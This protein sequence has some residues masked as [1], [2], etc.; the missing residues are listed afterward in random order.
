MARGRNDPVT[1]AGI[2]AWTYGL[3]IQYGV[4]RADDSALRAV[5]EAA[6]IAAGNSNDAVLI[7]TEY[8]LAVTLLNRS[9]VAGRQRGVELMTRA[10]EVWLREGILF[11]VP[12]T[13]LWVARETARR[14]DHDA[15]LPLMRNVVADMHQE[16]RLGYGVWATGVLVQTLLERGLESDLAE[17]EEV[18]DRLANLLADEL[19]DAR[20]HTASDARARGSGPRQQRRLPGFGEPLSRDGEIA[21]LRGPH[22][23]GRGD[24]VTAAASVCAGC[25][26]EV[27]ARDRFCHE[28]GARITASPDP[29]E[30][31][32]VTVLFADAVR[33]MDIAAALDIE[34]LREI[35][36]ALVERSA[37]VVQRY[38]GTVEHTGD[39]VMALFGA[40][41]ALEDHAFR[42]CL[43]RWPSRSKPTGWRPKY[44]GAMAWPCNCGWASIQAG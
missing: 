41:V 27:R 25:S 3:A 28:C 29:A 16:A 10:R 6:Q 12:I 37:V 22:R 33:S 13:E 20:H 7:L 5:E 1:I 31:K 39:G 42:A 19:C 35:M 21:W 8:T 24:D 14:G 30:Y 44:N 34:R 18:I 23:L 32:Q 40:P 26:A 17:A 9:S 15:V 2:V 11:L 4:L 36:T 38:G 43:A